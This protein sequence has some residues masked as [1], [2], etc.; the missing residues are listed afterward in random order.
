MTN[1]RP[2]PVSAPGYQSLY[3]GGLRPDLELFVYSVCLQKDV[4]THTITAMKTH[5]QKATSGKS[6]KGSANP[7]FLPRC[8]DFPLIYKEARQI[9]GLPSEREID[10]EHLFAAAN[11]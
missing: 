11:H 9:D 5:L 1:N 6:S 3:P 8:C 10:I 2:V 7:C 4:S